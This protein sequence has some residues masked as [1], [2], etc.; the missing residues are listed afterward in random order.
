M[1]GDQDEITPR[2]RSAGALLEHLIAQGYDITQTGNTLAIGPDSWEAVHV[3]AAHGYP[4]ES[5]GRTEGTV[6]TPD[7]SRVH[8]LLHPLPPMLLAGSITRALIDGIEREP[9]LAVV[10]TA[11]PPDSGGAR[12]GKRF[13]TRE[14]KY[15][16]REAGLARQKI[17][18]E[19]VDLLEDT[20]PLAGT[21]LPHHPQADIAAQLLLDAQLPMGD[22][23]QTLVSLLTRPDLLAAAA[24]LTGPELPPPGRVV[25]T[26]RSGDSA[27]PTTRD[28]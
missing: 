4:I 24:K 10:L 14:P 22:F 20:A 26:G 13:P 23:H 28:R 6:T 27:A 17:V 8:L 16:T 1:S 18:S 7:G 3:I 15:P 25:M 12:R 5:W 11:C 9:E 19:A 2:P 21:T